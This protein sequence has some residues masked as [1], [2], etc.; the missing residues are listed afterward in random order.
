M[1]SEREPFFAAI[2][3][4]VAG[5]VFIV[6]GFGKLVVLP[7]VARLRPGIPTFAAVLAAVHV[8]LPFLTSLAVCTLEIVGG[9]AL[10]TRR[11]VRPASALLALDMLGALISL[12][13]PA[14]F[15][16]RPVVLGSI[17]LGNEIW[18]VPLE[19]SLFLA[20]LWL[21]RLRTKSL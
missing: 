15:F 17:T 9:V 6:A 10:L 16:H 4:I 5:L 3:R 12:S 14:T 11:F 1:S 2:A 20:L 18:R 13:V 19:V 7:I 8:P 21:A